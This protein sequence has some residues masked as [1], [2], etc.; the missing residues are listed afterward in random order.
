MK[1]SFIKRTKL[2]LASLLVRAVGAI[3]S[4]TGVVMLVWYS[5]FSS[6]EYKYII[7]IYFFVQMYIGYR[8][9]KFSFER[10]YNEFDHHK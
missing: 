1:Y 10:M 6:K 4:T 9:V 8:V 5:F 3:L 2:I 7:A